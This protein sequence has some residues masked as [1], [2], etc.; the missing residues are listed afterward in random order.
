MKL[1]LGHANESLTYRYA[2]QLRKDV[3]LR[4]HWAAKVGLG[5]QLPDSI[6]ATVQPETENVSKEVAA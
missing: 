4:Q 1:W 3:D 6:C 5:F 2:E